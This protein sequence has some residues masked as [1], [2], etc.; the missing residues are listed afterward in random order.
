MS[1]TILNTFEFSTD[2]LRDHLRQLRA[3]PL[4]LAVIAGTLTASHTA[5]ATPVWGG[6]AIAS[7][8]AMFL[9]ADVR[10]PLRLLMF[11]SAAATVYALQRPPEIPLQVPLDMEVTIV[12][13]GA[14]RQRHR[15]YV[16][17]ATSGDLPP[18]K[19]EIRTPIEFVLRADDKFHV[20][21]PICPFSSEETPYSRNRERLGFTGFIK[22][23]PKNISDF[24]TTE[25]PPMQHRIA[26]T[27]DRI[28]PPSRG[29]AIALSI[30]IGY[31]NEVD[32]TTALQFNKSGISHLL[33]VS[34]LHIALVLMLLTLLF[35]PFGT[36]W[37]GFELRI[38]MTL[39]AIWFYVW[40]CG[41]TPSAVRAATLF[42]AFLISKYL[43]G[44]TSLLN[45]LMLSL[46]AL[47]LTEPA[48]LFDVGLQ[49]SAIAVMSISLYALPLIRAV[50]CNNMI[51]NDCVGLLSISAITTLALQPLV[52][53]TFGSISFWAILLNPL[54]IFIGNIILT[55]VLASTATPPALQPLIIEWATSTSELLATIAEFITNLGFGYADVQVDGATVVAIYAILAVVTLFLAGFRRCEEQNLEDI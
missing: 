31:R 44:T 35:R 29:R 39:I 41:M 4:L 18:F 13:D 55:L 14:L 45:V 53:Q 48:L 9:F 12:E 21:T 10:T 51:I 32:V 50:R 30:G 36:L 34:G 11:A 22:V 28:V 33:A 43:A 25:Y 3:L 1:F 2:T 7:M 42:S 49:L 19:V 20:H 47:L 23:T 38:A 5:V 40:M 52:A 27:F 15:T 26:D 17:N 37:R 16:A 6:I 24:V 46:T 8:V 54:A